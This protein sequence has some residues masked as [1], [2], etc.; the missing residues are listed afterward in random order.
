MKADKKY[1]LLK[2]EFVKL[3]NGTKLYR[4]MALRDILSDRLMVLAGQKGGFVE[5]ERNLSQSGDSWVFDGCVVRENAFV[6]M[7][8]IIK[9][10]SE[11]WGEAYITGSAVVKNCAICKNSIVADTCVMND[12]VISNSGKYFGEMIF[13]GVQTG[14]IG[15]AASQSKYGEVFD[16][17]R[18]MER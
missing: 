1:T 4:I 3:S 14:D 5:S 6:C 11:I 8:A 16:S 18:A 9:G 2:D 12:C 17:A 7:D 15:D 13:D 10:K